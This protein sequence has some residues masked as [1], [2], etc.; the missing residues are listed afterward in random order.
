VTKRPGRNQ[1]LGGWGERVAAHYLET[2]NYQVL[3][4]NYRT[5]FGEIDLICQAGDITIFVEVKTRSGL[6]FGY[7][8]EAVTP[9]K[10]THLLDAIQFFW[11]SEDRVEGVWRVDV[12]AV[13]GR[14]G[15]KE[16][17]QIEHFEN[18]VV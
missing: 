18:A 6:D 4:A 13:I 2:I 9:S 3:H 14:P 8:E 11:Q 15:R 12:V 5:P 7:P 10:R 16:P 17:P 1:R